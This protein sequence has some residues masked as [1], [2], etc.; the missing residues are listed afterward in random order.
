[1]WNGRYPYLGL[2]AFQESDAKY[3]FGRESLVDD[4]LERV[5]KS[6]FITIAGPSGSGKSSVARAGLFY[7]LRE[8]RLEK[9]DG[10]LLATMQPKG[11]P[12]GQ[13]A[14]SIDRMMARPGAGDYLRKNGMGNP[15]ALH[16]QIEPLLQEDK[17]HRC[18]LLVDQFEGTFTQTKDDEVR[19]AFINLLTMAAQAD[20]GRIIILLSL[21]SDFIS[22]CTRYS[23][24]SSLMSQQLQLVGAMKPP[25]IAKAITL[26]AL[27]VGA[28]IDPELV[29][30]IMHG[31]HERGA[32]C[33]AANELCP[34]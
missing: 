16:E 2:T 27:K 33:A 17:S 29:S 24:L 22:H 21:R 6:R 12:I 9:S 8:G 32:G 18:I 7:A 19:A 20:G 10:W 23:D 25:D 28:K 14:A 31:R 34:A 3:F 30:R 1:M 15:L 26:P 5:Q 11:A 13:L 4:L